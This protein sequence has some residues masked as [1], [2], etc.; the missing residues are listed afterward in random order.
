MSVDLMNEPDLV[1]NVLE[2]LLR[3]PDAEDTVEGI[4]EW[5]LLEQQIRHKVRDVSRVLDNLVAKGFLVMS[6]ST[7]PG[8]PKRYRLDKSREREIR[9][10]LRSRPDSRLSNGSDSL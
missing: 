9:E 1:S 10:Y 3:H 4:T 6:H 2:Y 7:T 5:W 8:Q